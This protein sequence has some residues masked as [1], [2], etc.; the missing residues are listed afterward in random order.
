MIGFEALY[1]GDSASPRIYFVDHDG[2]DLGSRQLSFVE[3]DETLANQSD[4]D[5]GYSSRL[6]E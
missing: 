1:R 2:L 5:F 3:I 6:K 4:E